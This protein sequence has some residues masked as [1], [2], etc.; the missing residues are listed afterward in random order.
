MVIA[1]LFRFDVLGSPELQGLQLLNGFAT[2]LIRTD[3]SR[4]FYTQEYAVILEFSPHSAL[5]LEFFQLFRVSSLP[6]ESKQNRL[7]LRPTST[8]RR[9]SSPKSGHPIGDLFLAMVKFFFV[10]GW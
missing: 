8:R 4:S 7:C 3:E 5:I 2:K 6:T 9:F 1:P 10:L